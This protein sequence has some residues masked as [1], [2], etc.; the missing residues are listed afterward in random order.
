MARCSEGE[1]KKPRAS[2]FP[3]GS[4][5]TRG[6]QT[7]FFSNILSDCTSFKLKSCHVSSAAAFVRSLKFVFQHLS[8]VN[9]AESGSKILASSLKCLQDVDHGVRAAFRWV[10]LKS[11]TISTTVFVWI[12]RI[13]L[14]RNSTVSSQGEHDSGI[15]R[16]D[17]R[18]SQVEPHFRCWSTA[19]EHPLERLWNDVTRHHLSHGDSPVHCGPCCMVRGLTFLQV[20][21]LY[22]YVHHK[23]LT[24]ISTFQFA[25]TQTAT[26]WR[27]CWGC[28]WTV[29]VR[30]C[31]MAA[32][33]SP[34]SNSSEVAQ[35]HE[36]KLPPL[37]PQ[38]WPRVVT[39]EEHSS[40]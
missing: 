18:A 5:H 25:A 9:S 4:A 8:D 10:L 38:T 35:V 19:Y 33:C 39:G 11:L 26:F 1:S 31:Q 13:S 37:V 2:I 23:R 3:I 20:H 24:I 17:S 29:S 16:H 40:L 28:W 34:S 15:D 7:R 21:V 14:Q 12:C 32:N 22:M 27:A 30:P 36:A 6:S